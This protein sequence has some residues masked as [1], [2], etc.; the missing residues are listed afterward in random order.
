MVSRSLLQLDEI[1]N[2]RVWGFTYQET[3]RYQNS[4]RKG[5]FFLGRPEG[6]RKFFLRKTRRNHLDYPEVK[7][8]LLFKG[9]LRETPR[10]PKGECKSYL[11]NTW[12]KYINHPKAKVDISLGNTRRKHLDYPKVKEDFSEGNLMELPNLPKKGK[13]DFVLGE[14]PEETPRLPDGQRRF[15]WGRLKGKAYWSKL[16][17][18]KLELYDLAWEMLGSFYPFEMP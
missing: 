10:L 12:R 2:W 3:Q 1:F 7:E 9:N 17:L 5:G 11:R 18:T 15:F 14:Y 6:E 13:E 16:M 8:Y 4:W